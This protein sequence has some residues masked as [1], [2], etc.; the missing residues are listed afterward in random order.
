MNFDE[1]AKISKFHRNLQNNSLNFEVGAVQRFVSPEDLFGTGQKE[2]AQHARDLSGAA[3][4]SLLDPK[5]LK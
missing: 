3:F 4:H 1:F 5:V 2:T